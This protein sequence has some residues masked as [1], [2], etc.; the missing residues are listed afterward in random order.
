MDNPEFS[1]PAFTCPSCW[2]AFDAGDVL[3]VATHE[4]L[5]GD[6]LLGEDAPLRFLPIRFDDAGHAI[7]PM[8]Q[9][10]SQLACPHCRRILPDGFL[11]IPHRICS[12]VGAPSSGKSYYLSVLIKTLADTLSRRFG[13][14]LADG[15]P[16]GNVLL[17]QMKNRLFSA[18]TPEEAVLAKTALE[19]AMYERFPRFGKWVSLPRPF[20]YRVG[21]PKAPERAQAL[22]FYDN[23]GEHFEPGIDTEDS[24]GAMHVAHSDILFFLFD[25]T[26]NTRF[27]RRLH[28]SDDPQISQH[29]RLDQQDSILA[30]MQTRVKKI[31]GTPTGEKI[32]TPLAFIV[33]KSDVLKPL[34]DWN[35][36]QNPVAADGVLDQSV[37]DA[38]SERIRALLLDIDPALVRQAEQLARVVRY[39]PVSAFGRAPVSVTDKEG[40]TFLAPDPAT[41]APWLVEIPALWALSR[42]APDLVPSR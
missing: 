2:R 11:E 7:D 30:E 13:R 33:G 17:N 29:A 4:S 24:P 19:G 39:F 35:A 22:V 28:G 40:A 36:F 12:L 21:D 32:E 37:L 34:V 9:P 18:H 31:L 3:S 6:P 10:T 15:D 25:P 23:A 42:L 5:R 41:L 1:R 38:N 14:A 27:R 8:G 20:V 16:T 26:A